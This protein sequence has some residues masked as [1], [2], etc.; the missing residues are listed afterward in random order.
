M[1]EQGFQPRLLV[2]KP[3]ALC[4]ITVAMPFLEESVLV[5][6]KMDHKSASRERRQNPLQMT[7]PLVKVKSHIP[8]KARRYLVNLDCLVQ[9][10]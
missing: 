9:I 1:D 5:G 8:L 3:N 4:F 10:N 6:C 2:S 7:S